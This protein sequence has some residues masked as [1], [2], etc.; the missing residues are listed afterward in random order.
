MDKVKKVPEISAEEK[1]IIITQANLY[2]ELGSFQKAAD[3]LG[4]SYNL[5]RRNLR[6][7]LKYID[8]EL[9]ERVILESQTSKVIRSAPYDDRTIKRI[10]NSYQLF[11][12]EK[13]PLQEVCNM[14]K[15]SAIVICLDLTTRI[16]VLKNQG[17]NVSEEMLENINKA[18]DNEQS[19]R[20]KETLNILQKLYPNRK[21][22]ISFL[23]SCT[24]TFG[25]RLD[26]LS[27]ILN[28]QPNFLY[29]EFMA[30]DIK[31]KDSL[32]FHF[33]HGFVAEEEAI[34]NFLDFL[35]RLAY[36]SL[37]HDREKILN[38][39][40]E[41]GDIEVINF[42]KNHKPGASVSDY[43]LIILLKY[44]L[45]H[46]VSHFAIADYFGINPTTYNVRILGLEKEYP[47]L[48]SYY[49][50]VEDY[51]ETSRGRK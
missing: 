44:Q 24:I 33:F 27:R 5:I 49:I 41:I 32:T 34:E 37:S 12:V 30:S 26:Y 40:S 31:V 4:I 39:L 20:D 6:E 13:K 28:K 3:R 42:K 16:R 21:K 35:E 15:A 8:E 9:Y 36:A 10:F 29:D 50:F 22:L 14:L 47:K 17:Y 1:E 7:K 43:E 51:R 38:V 46:G 23:A 2:L 18:L 25:L 48:V 11:V 45:K 19:T